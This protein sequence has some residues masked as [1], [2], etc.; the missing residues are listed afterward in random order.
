MIELLNE[1]IIE[2]KS[3]D[4]TL[5]MPEMIAFFRLRLKPVRFIVAASDFLTLK[6]YRFRH[7]KSGKPFPAAAFL[8][9]G[10]SNN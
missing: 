6:P 8:H 3:V 5:L 7:K 10:I 2:L 9:Y 4:E 1:R